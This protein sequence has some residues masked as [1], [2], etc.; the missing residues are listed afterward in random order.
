[1]CIRDS[2]TSGW[3]YV[4]SGSIY[5]A[6]DWKY[7]ASGSIYVAS[8]GIYVTSALIIIVLLLFKVWKIYWMRIKYKKVLQIFK[9]VYSNFKKQI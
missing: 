1:M 6:S 8:D 3:Y 5:V 7:V 2:V 9:I 4:T